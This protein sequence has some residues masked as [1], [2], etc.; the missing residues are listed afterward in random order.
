MSWLA[1]GLNRWDW[2]SPTH[3]VQSVVEAEELRGDQRHG[4]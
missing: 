3:Y 4:A 2:R 1:F